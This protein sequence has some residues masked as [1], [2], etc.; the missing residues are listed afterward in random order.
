MGKTENTT[1][2]EMNAGSK[3]RPKLLS[4]IRSKVL[5]LAVGSFHHVYINSRFLNTISEYPGIKEFFL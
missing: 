2:A 4:E 1:N 5:Y 3:G